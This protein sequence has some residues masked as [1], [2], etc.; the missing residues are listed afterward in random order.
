MTNTL[1]RLRCANCRTFRLKMMN[2]TGVV[3]ALT[4]G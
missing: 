1:R 2:A 3:S 4:I